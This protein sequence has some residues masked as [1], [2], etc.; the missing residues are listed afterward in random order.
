MLY[1][2]LA[3]IVPKDFVVPER[4]DCLHMVDFNTAEDDMVWPLLLLSI[5]LAPMPRMTEAQVKP[6]HRPVV[7]LPRGA[8]SR[9][10][11]PDRKW[12]LIFECP[13]DCSE[14]KL[15]I[16]ENTSH[17]RKLVKEYERSLSIS[18]A[19]DS[20]LF[21]VNDASGSTETLCY[22]YDPATLKETDLAKV[23]VAGDPKAG[24]YVGAGHSYLKAKRWINSRELIVV[25][26]GHF[27]E[28]PPRGFTLRYRVNLNGSV[29]KLS[30]H[31][32]EEPQ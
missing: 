8:V 17:R 29:Q 20:R 5:F 32:E 15:W 9:I 4:F 22:I 30:Q 24:E 1:G 10:P 13:N 26:Y 25:L 18:W 12:T 23:V 31:S 27:D 28:P 3:R 11:S 2:H 6:A 16:E 21:F 19:P 7:H 14:R